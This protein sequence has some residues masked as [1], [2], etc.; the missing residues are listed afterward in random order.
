[1]ASEYMGA[2][3]TPSYDVRPEES[4]VE[5]GETLLGSGEQGETKLSSARAAADEDRFVPAPLP[6]GYRMTGSG[7]PIQM[8]C[9]DSRG[10]PQSDPARAEQSMEPTGVATAPTSSSMHRLSPSHCHSGTA[11]SSVHAANRS[12]DMAPGGNR[13]EHGAV[14]DVCDTSE[15]FFTIPQG[16]GLGIIDA[17]DHDIGAVDWLDETHALLDVAREPG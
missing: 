4:I 11:L 13:A 7:P 10:C 12:V 14:G 1:M 5:T 6:S 2:F 17:D 15:T 8:T 3:K 16:T 9:K